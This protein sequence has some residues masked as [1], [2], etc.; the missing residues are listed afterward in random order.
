MLAVGLLAFVVLL[1]LVVL[2]LLLIVIVLVVT[3]VI[4]VL[5]GSNM[6][7]VV[8]V[9]LLCAGLRD[10]ELFPGM[11]YN[12]LIGWTELNCNVLI[13]RK[14]MRVEVNLLVSGG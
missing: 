1:G 4:V 7:V 10:V 13:L 11:A 12:G 9:V 8:V 2:C 3:V 14:N 6:R 5:F